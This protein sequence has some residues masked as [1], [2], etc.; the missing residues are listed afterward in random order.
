MHILLKIA[1]TTVFVMMMAHPA[2]CD[3]HALVVGINEY[4]HFGKLDGAVNDA[5]DLADALHKLR[6]KKVITLLDQQASRDAIL[7]AW[8]TLANEAKAGDILI[9][10]YAGHGSQSK[11]RIP[12][13]EEDGLDE[14]YVLTHFNPNGPDSRERIL[15]DDIA[16][17]IHNAP[18]LQTMVISDSCHSGTMTRGTKKGLLKYRRLPQQSITNDAM[19]EETTATRGIDESAAMQRA[20]SFSAVSDREEVPEITIDA[21]QRG[22]MSWAMANGLRGAADLNRDGQITQQELKSYVNEKIRTVTD[23]IQHPQIKTRNAIH[24]TL[25]TDRP[26]SAVHRNKPAMAETR[27]AEL[28]LLVKPDHHPVITALSKQAGIKV[29]DSRLPGTWLLDVANNS[30]VSPLGDVHYDFS[31][32]SRGFV[33]ATPDTPSDPV[34]VGTLS[35]TELTHALNKV[36]LVERIKQLDQ[37]NGLALALLPDDRHYT[38]GAAVT[39]RL[40]NLQYPYLTLINLGADGTINFL[41]PKSKLN[42]TVDIP[43]NKPYDLSLTV[44]PP[45]GADHF[46][47]IASK[48]VLKPLHG[49]L[50]ALD[51]GRDVRK[52]GQLFEQY[53]TPSVEYQ[54]GVHGVFTG[55]K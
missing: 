9:F 8:K 20:V 48:T 10:S 17:M 40:S 28:P 53:L 43:I 55:L 1:L 18:H 21:K 30:L 37:E 23:G 4:K 27:S 11:E 51:G 22:A 36:M 52:I 46:V 38:K 13:S 44:A 19:T 42:D 16:E 12:G 24:L 25:N 49:E 45:F 32:I 14:F 35:M 34:F 2:W 33:R 26:A 50:E 54:I 5:R 29:V 41:Y 47:A 3:I 7:G 15:D 39:L 6:A 31:R